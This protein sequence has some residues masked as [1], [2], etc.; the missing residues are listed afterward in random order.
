MDVACFETIRDN[1]VKLCIH[2]SFRNNAFERALLGGERA[3]RR[4][5]GLTTVLSSE[6]TRV[7]RLTVGF[8]GGTRGLYFK[9]YLSRSL[10]DFVKQLVRAS[11]AKR[12]LRGCLMLE[13]N[14]FKTSPV[15]AAG[16]RIFGFMTTTSFLVTSEIET[17]KGIHQWL[18]DGFGELS[19]EQLEL[20]RD[21]IRAFG[22]TIGRM[23][24]A[25]IFHGDLRLANVLARREKN[26]WEFFF[27]DNERTRKFR[28]L[29]GRLRLKNL[30]QA[31]MIEQDITNTDRMRF[32]REYKGENAISRREAE[33]LTGKILKKTSRRLHCRNKR[34]RGAK[35]YL[36]T[37]KNYLRIREG[38][39]IAVFD[40]V[41][42][43]AAES[44][45]LI[46][47]IDALMDA[48]E[49]LK[50]DG[51][52]YVSRVTC[53]GKDI[54]VKR[55]NHRGLIHSLRHTIKKSRARRCWLNAHRLG[56][57][58]IAT[59]K[60]LAYIERR[61]GG[62]LWESYF[63]TK[64]VKGQ[65]LYDFLRED[66]RGC[67]ERADLAEQ[68]QELLEQLSKHRITHGDLKHTN[69]LVTDNGPVLTDLDAMEVHKLGWRFRLKKRKD[70][71][72]LEKLVFKS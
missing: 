70:L 38:G 14:G 4:Y 28:K 21:L 60:P 42:Y 52:S 18:S 41:F 1:N 43:Q 26:G 51:S 50:S 47:Q 5:C 56:V 3:I 71:S 64:Y 17:A 53:N 12:A 46:R 19:G 20:K 68:L 35:V 32:F 61:K 39:R 10:W 59:P 13:E 30:V 36:R 69:I 72:L 9:R 58:N 33:R 11:K 29:P 16:E 23:H 24:A 54:V 55:Y 44:M 25:G 67:K 63:I 48:G 49:V 40:R 66:S 37:N 31:N 6:F 45:D 2:T 7:Y 34:D 27:L 15:V 8:E 65:R 57:L 62:L 22:R